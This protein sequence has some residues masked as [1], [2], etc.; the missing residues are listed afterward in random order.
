MNVYDFD[1]TI[2][3]PDSS[4]CFIRFCLRHYPRAVSRAVLPS[5]WQGLLYLLEGRKDAQ[6]LKQ[7]LFSFLNRIDNIERVVDEFWKENL[8]RVELWY[9][10]QKKS[11]D[12]IISASPEFLLRP[13]ADALG[14][15]LI[16]TPMNPYTGEIIGK[17]CHDLEKERRFLELFSADQLEEFYSDSLSDTPMAKLAER[18]FLVIG[19]QFTPWP[20]SKKD[21][22]QSRR[23]FGA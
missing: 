16:A 2:F 21:R 3:T 15:R 11:D 23:F 4:A 19:G 22:F 17:N 13:A 12:L 9:L 8:K 7:S 6:Q 10:Q 5:A 18:A 1:N 20:D 14:V